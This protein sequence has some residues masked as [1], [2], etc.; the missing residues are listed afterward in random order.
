MT[1]LSV[2]WTDEHQHL[3]R[4]IRTRTSLDQLPTRRVALVVNLTRNTPD[5][6]RTCNPRFRRPMRYPIAPRAPTASTTLSAFSS[7]PGFALGKHRFA[8]EQR[9]CV[10][11]DVRPIICVIFP[12]TIQAMTP[13]G[14][15]EIA[16]F[17]EFS[18]SWVDHPV[19]DGNDNVRIPKEAMRAALANLTAASV[20][21]HAILGCCW[22]HG[23][24]CTSS[25]STACV[26]DEHEHAEFA[27]D[28]T[29]GHDACPGESGEHP[30]PHRHHCHDRT[31]VATATNGPNYDS[32]IQLTVLGHA[33]VF[34]FSQLTTPQSA[35]DSVASISP[36]ATL[37][38]RLHL[39]QG[40]LLI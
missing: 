17:S 33:Y 6:I 32:L 27:H 7:I 26:H 37:P 18:A 2:T 12:C 1:Q 30:T 22:H 10:H 25:D 39:F 8:I 36:A 23:H 9:G 15:S 24:S 16:E 29:A 4:S 40:L 34:E 21:I 31:C 38:M 35:I 3:C 5:R 28:R 11:L 13:R 19:D 20:L 14:P